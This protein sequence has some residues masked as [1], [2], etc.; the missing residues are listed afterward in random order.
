MIQFTSTRVLFD[1]TCIDSVHGVV[2]CS[3][4]FVVG[5]VYGTFWVCWSQTQ[6]K[7]QGGK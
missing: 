3:P 4:S 6:P 2:Y 5:Y 7:E 1:A